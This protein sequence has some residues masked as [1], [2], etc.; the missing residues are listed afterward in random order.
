[1]LGS[2]IISHFYYLEEDKTMKILI[3]KL[4]FPIH[5]S[6]F[7]LILSISNAN[8][9][10][11]P[12]PL[13]NK[14]QQLQTKTSLKLSKYFDKSIHQPLIDA[15]LADTDEL[16]ICI[17][18]GATSTDPVTDLK[19]CHM[20]LDN[21]SQGLEN[22]FGS[23]SNPAALQVKTKVWKKAQKKVRKL[24]ALATVILTDLDQLIVDFENQQPS[25]T[26][27]LPDPQLIVIRVI[28]LPRY[29]PGLNSR[30]SSR[31]MYRALRYASSSAASVPRYLANGN[32]S[33]AIA[34]LGFVKRWIEIY[35]NIINNDLANNPQLAPE[36][37]TAT[38][39]V[40][41]QAN[42]LLTDIEILIANL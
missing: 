20:A 26:Q 11:D 7:L 38:Q 34:E 22:S 27:S 39:Q 1:M 32:T 10:T 29:I 31:S 41:D 25:T 3:R 13:L 24:Q 35:I 15:L 40:L 36:I 19:S 30:T 5:L 14:V 18:T 37:V 33:T 28:K 2:V 21:Y 6:L 17:E 23:G 16:S 42:S 12:G 9:A 4:L 8:A